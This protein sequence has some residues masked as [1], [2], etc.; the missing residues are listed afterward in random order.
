MVLFGTYK[1]DTTD[2]TVFDLDGNG[3]WVTVNQKTV[4]TSGNLNSWYMVPSSIKQNN[5]VLMRNV[6]W[7]MT[8]ADPPGKSALFGNSLTDLTPPTHGHRSAGKLFSW[9]VI[10]ITILLM[11]KSIMKVYPSLPVR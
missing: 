6:A 11:S 2:L 8:S 3:A 4:P 10:V 5:G 9:E 1:F 7:T